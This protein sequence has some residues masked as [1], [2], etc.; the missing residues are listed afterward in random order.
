MNPIKKLLCAAII[1]FIPSLSYG[2]EAIRKLLPAA[3]NKNSIY[4]E[5]ATFHNNNRGSSLYILKNVRWAKQK[6]FERIVF[7]IESS[8]EEK[9]LPYFQI[10]IEPIS[11]RITVEIKDIKKLE[12]SVRSKKKW[13]KSSLIKSFYV[14]PQMEGNLVSINI[15]LNKATLLESFYLLNPKRIVLDLKKK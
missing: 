10:N 1:F 14:F 11:R 3:G 7:D 5:E 6:D 2:T 13:D 4:L 12:P 9:R 8:P 15:K